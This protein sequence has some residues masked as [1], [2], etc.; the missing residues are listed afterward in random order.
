MEKDWWLP[1]MVEGRQGVTAEGMGFPL[2]V[3]R[4]SGMR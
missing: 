1:D 3:Q 4:I 2:G